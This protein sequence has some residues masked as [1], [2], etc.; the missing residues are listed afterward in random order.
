MPRQSEHRCRLE[1]QAF[2]GQFFSQMDT[3]D[4]GFKHGFPDLRRIPAQEEPFATAQGRNPQPCIAKIVEAIRLFILAEKVFQRLDPSAG[5]KTP[6]LVRQMRACQPEER[7][8]R[9]PSV[10]GVTFQDLRHSPF[11]ARRDG[12]DKPLVKIAPI[13]LT[14]RNNLVARRKKREVPVNLSPQILH[15][16]LGTSAFSAR[17]ASPF[18]AFGVHQ[19]RNF[20]FAAFQESG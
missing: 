2:H 16:H 9:A 8:K 15:P 13:H 18:A 19:R 4:A 14:G 5:L 6:A 3:A 1:V 10:K 20:F 7:R 17:R 12:H 11:A